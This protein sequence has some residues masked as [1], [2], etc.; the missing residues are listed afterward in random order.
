MFV[1]VLLFAL[2]AYAQI[3]GGRGSAIYVTTNAALREIAL[4]PR[5][6]RAGFY[7]AGDGGAAVYTWNTSNCAAPDNGAQ[8][9]PSNVTGCWIAD[10]SAIPANPIV[11]GAKGDGTTDDSAAINAALSATTALGTELQI[12]GKTFAVCAASIALPFGTKI[13]GLVPNLSKLQTQASCTGPAATQLVLLPNN[14]SDFGFVNVIHNGRIQDL[15]LDGYGLSKWVINVPSVNDWSFLGLTVRNP[16]P[17]SVSTAMTNATTVPGNAI[18]HFA[19]TPAGAIAGNVIDDT[20]RP[21]VIPPGATVVRANSGDVTLSTNVTAYDDGSGVGSADT[22]RF[23]TPTAGLYLQGGD[24]NH[25]EA[26]R[27]ENFNDPGHTLYTS[28][29][30]L[31]MAGVYILGH[32]DSDFVGLKVVNAMYGVIDTDGYGNTFL[33]PHVWGEDVGRIYDLRPQYGFAVANGTS[34]YRA[35]ADDPQIAGLYLGS[36]PAAG[37]SEAIVDGLVTNYTAV[38]VGGYTSSYAALIASGVQSGT[39]RAVN[40]YVLS[41]QGA[42]A[43]IVYQRGVPSSNLIVRDNPDALYSTAGRVL[44]GSATLR[45]GDTVEYLGPG[46]ATTT[47]ASVWPMPN[48]CYITGILV[49]VAATLRKGQSY[50]FEVDNAGFPTTITASMGSGVYFIGSKIPPANTNIASTSAFISAGSSISIKVTPSGT[51]SRNVLNYRLYTNC[52]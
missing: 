14:S 45:A 42:K 13:R 36:S 48:S 9:Q 41:F 32:A 8:V 37:G 4:G 38:P 17:S 46:G 40:S 15:V 10:F 26:I 25:W 12:P 23:M 24:Q 51:P 28:Q 6:M 34:I 11:W 31:P 35:E 3:G 30:T 49:S 2:P 22:I 19:S 16:A 44:E 29:T 20:S 21:G 50:A 5:V 1:A 52:P 33:S 43:N 39:L 47:G 7:S 27:V 18:L